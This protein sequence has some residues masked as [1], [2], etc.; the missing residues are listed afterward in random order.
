MRNVTVRV[1]DIVAL[2]CIVNFAMQIAF[3]F[4]ADVDLRSYFNGICLGAILMAALTGY[5]LNIW[6]NKNDE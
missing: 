3:V 4:S 1:G 2:S 6:G 5:A